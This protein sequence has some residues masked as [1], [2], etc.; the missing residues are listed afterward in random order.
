M[1]YAKVTRNRKC[2]LDNQMRGMAV[3]RLRSADSRNVQK[4]IRL[5]DSS[6]GGAKSMSKREW[7]RYNLGRSRIAPRAN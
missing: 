4:A 3:G 2:L 1:E 7:I 5:L 6:A